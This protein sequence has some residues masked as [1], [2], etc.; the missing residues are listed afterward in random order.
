MHLVLLHYRNFL[1]ALF[2]GVFH[3]HHL[4]IDLIEIAVIGFVWELNFTFSFQYQVKVVASH[5]ILNY[6]RVFFGFSV[7]EQAESVGNFWVFHLPIFEEW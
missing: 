6:K 2:D 5:A 7:R 3:A 4:P 1:L